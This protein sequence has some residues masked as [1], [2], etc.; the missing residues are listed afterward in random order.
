MTAQWNANGPIPPQ[1]TGPYRVPKSRSRMY[2]TLAAIGALVI[3]LVVVLL[4]APWRTDDSVGPQSHA[5]PLDDGVSTVIDPQGGWRIEPGVVD[6]SRGVMI[7][8]RDDTRSLDEILH[9]VSWA[10]YQVNIVSRPLTMT[11]CASTGA[12]S[13]LSVPLGGGVFPPQPATNATTATMSTTTSFHA[14]RICPLLVFA[15]RCGDGPSCSPGGPKGHIAS[16]G[17]DERS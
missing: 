14:A 1:Y 7:I 11:S 16:A 10:G 17:R 15:G 13:S 5:I 3:A 8:P 4:V 9:E 6:G 2:A 12:G